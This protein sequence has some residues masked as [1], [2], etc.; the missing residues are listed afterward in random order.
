MAY[1]SA[2]GKEVTSGATFCGNCGAKVGEAQ[3]RVSDPIDPPVVTG[4]AV[5]PAAKA[6]IS[7]KDKGT[8]ILLSMLLGVIG[9]DRFYRGQIGLG[10]LKLI[11]FG[12]CFIWAIIDTFVYLL[13]GLP[14]D[15]AGNTIVDKK[16]ADFIRSGSGNQ[17]VSMKDKDIMILLAGFLG[18]FG[19]DR[20]YRGQVGL[21]ILKLITLGGCGI[22]SFIDLIIYTVGSLQTDAEGKTIVD[23]K[24]KQYI[25][26]LG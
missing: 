2:C 22:W 17:D 12:G 9:V 21:G 14:P 1:C 3:A 19:I 25:N 13:G 11:T 23:Q 6:A 20:F 7:L 8:T 18:G 16:T 26:E 15:S 4:P 5:Q 24:T 10:I